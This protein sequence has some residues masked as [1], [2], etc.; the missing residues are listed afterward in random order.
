V[1]PLQPGDVVTRLSAAIERNPWRRVFG[2]DQP[3]SGELEGYTFLLVRNMCYRN[4]RPRIRGRIEP[5]P[6]GGARLDVLVA[7]AKLA[8]EEIIPG[9]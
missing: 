3:F 6:K 4:V 9:K 5:S 7:K 2:S 1:T 8:A